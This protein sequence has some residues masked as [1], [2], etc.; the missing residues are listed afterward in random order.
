MAML[1]RST[2]TLGVSL[3]LILQFCTGA[4]AT[5][6][7]T[8]QIPA[9][10]M[11]EDA[12]KSVPQLFTLATA[13]EQALKHNK[14]VLSAKEEL[15]SAKAGKKR[16]LGA[17]LPHAYA[18]ML[19]KNQEGLKHRETNPDYIT[20]A[21]ND[22]RLGIN[23]TVF[24]M[25]TFSRYTG[26]GLQKERAALY[27][28]YVELDTLYNTEKE[29]FTLLSAVENVKSYRKSVERMQAQLKSALAFYARQMK[30][31]LHVLQM[32]TQ[33]A[34]AKSQLSAAEN[35][36]DTQR[37]RL[38]SI[39]SLPQDAAVIF[40]G[41]LGNVQICTLDRLSTYIDMA[42]KTRPDVLVRKKDAEI[43]KQ[44]EEVIEGEYYPKVSAFAEYNQKELDYGSVWNS[45][46]DVHYPYADGNHETY[47]VGLNVRWDFF[48]GTSTHYALKEQKR[49][50]QSAVFKYQ[51]LKEDV[52]AEVKRSYL[53]VIQYRNQINLSRA[54]VNE[55]QETYSRAD[56]RYKLGIGT[57]TEL[58]DASRELID[59]E[60]SLNTALADYN[61]ALAALYYSSGGFDQL[62]TLG[63]QPLVN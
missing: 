46:Y 22:R 19:A 36:V 30:P 24:D 57:S 27:L 48:E 42:F 52:A 41:S 62:K 38:I 3:L 47:A 16:A 8:C 49:K 18:S 9:G 11:I 13:L 28:K 39:L 61:T 45:N 21:S 59:A 23:Q 34:K 32:Q 60:V 53:D 7:V 29:F 37:A 50:T 51:K 35:R 33:L 26:A 14:T 5:E 15:L 12:S 44:G 4:C 17:M 54:Y 1:I 2:S 63:N 6:N 25:P 43:S 55:A 10:Q 40:K 56:K 31:R 20:Q 58:V